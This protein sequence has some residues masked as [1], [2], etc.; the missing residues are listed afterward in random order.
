M[1]S[2]EIDC[3]EHL[4]ITEY[5]TRGAKLFEFVCFFLITF[6]K[7]SFATVLRLA[8]ACAALVFVSAMHHCRK[9][10]WSVINGSDQAAVPVQ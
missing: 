10:R 3:L 6:P 1:G 4:Q 8:V 2:G 5:L 7:S 9:A